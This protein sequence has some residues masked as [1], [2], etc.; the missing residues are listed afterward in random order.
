MWWCCGCFIT[1]TDENDVEL[2]P[3]NIKN[4]LRP[5]LFSNLQGK[6]VVNRVIDGD[7]YELLVYI[8]LSTLSKEVI[9]GRQHEIK[10]PIYTEDLSSG[11][12]TIITC[13]LSGIDVAEHDTYHGL[14]AIDQI[15]NQLKKYNN[16]LYYKSHIK[17][18]KN[19]RRL[20]DEEDK[21]GR[22]ILEL[23]FDSNYSDNIND[24]FFNLRYNNQIIALPY[25]G[26][27]K[28]EYMKNLPKIK[29]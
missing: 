26:C 7:T 12:Y 29:K 27:A 3:I 1:E 8:P 10:Q 22:I 6:C 15:N 21:W 17:L 19:G 9:M 20:Q 4:K 13:R 18:G 14:Y 23:Y 25:D 24:F 2:L 28:N 5:F 11:F 16:V